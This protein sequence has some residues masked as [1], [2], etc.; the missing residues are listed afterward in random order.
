MRPA[1]IDRPAGT[2]DHLFMLFY[3]PVELLVEGRVERLPPRTLMLWPPGHRHYYGNRERA[4]RH[5]WIHCE[6][7]IGAPP[8][9]Q[10]CDFR[11]ASRCS[12]SIPPPLSDTCFALYEELTGPFVPDETIA[13]NHLEN[14]LREV[15]RRQ[16]SS[17]VRSGPPENLLKLRTYLEVHSAEPLRLGE[18]AERVS[19]SPQYLC[20]LF[21]RHF[22]VSPIDYVIRQRLQRAQYLLRNQNLAVGEVGRLVGYDD[23]FQ[24]SKLFKKRF[25]ESPR[26][27]RRR[28][29]GM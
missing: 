9:P 10:R 11:S 20:S 7:S 1:I 22:G 27:M 4:W 29:W 21:K 6:G 5:S 28:M 3:D 12:M 24:F 25:G 16:T 18:L 13:E 17:R 8:A 26:M 23:I 19:L 2:A 14:W 15:A